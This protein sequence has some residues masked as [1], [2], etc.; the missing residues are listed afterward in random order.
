MSEPAPKIGLYQKVRDELRLRNYSLKTIKSY[1]SCLRTFVDYLKPK[2]PRNIS[3]EDIRKFL[4]YLIEE[5][6]YQASTINQMFNALRFLYGELYKTPFILESI[7][8]PKKDQKLPDILSQEDI[9]KIFKKIKNLKHR[10]LIMLIY[11]AGL[12]VGEGVRLKITDIDSTRKMIHIRAAKGKKD[13]YTLLSDNVLNI[14]R[15]YYKRYHPKDYLFEGQGDRK[16]ISERSIQ[17]VFHRAVKEAGIKKNIS[18][19]GLRHSFA[20]HLLES[21]VDLRYIQELLGHHSSKTTEIY[22]HISKKSLSHIINP[23]D[24]AIQQ[25]KEK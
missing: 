4:L 11:S 22:T 3:N 24:A 16:H 1:L 15:E 25:R 14:L 18:V 8:R 17:A 13:R 12:R 7:P 23:L 9:L 6:K 5:K 21:G 20:T 10:T 19:H 2:H